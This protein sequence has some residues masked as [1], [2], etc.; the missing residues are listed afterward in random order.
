MCFRWIL[1]NIART[2]G[3]KKTYSYIFRDNFLEPDKSGMSY[4]DILPPLEIKAMQ[5]AAALF[6][7]THNF[8]SFQ[9]RSE[10]R[11]VTRDAP[12]NVQRLR[13]VFK[14]E[15]SRNQIHQFRGN[16]FLT[17]YG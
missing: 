16:R 15:S 6:V 1:K 9:V 11:C 12:L 7:G 13:T 17:T 8:Q 2:I 4:W 14:N 3:L 10:R 5:E